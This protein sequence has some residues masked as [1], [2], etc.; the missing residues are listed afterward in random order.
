MAITTTMGIGPTTITPTVKAR[1]LWSACRRRDMAMPS[2]PWGRPA[3]VGNNYAPASGVNTVDSDQSEPYAARLKGE[4]TRV[5]LPILN[6][7]SCRGNRRR[8]GGLRAYPDPGA[9]AGCDVL[10]RRC[11]AATF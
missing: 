2:L 1:S 9:A 7:A 4:T 6:I 11:S 10:Q 3:K 8:A 5:S